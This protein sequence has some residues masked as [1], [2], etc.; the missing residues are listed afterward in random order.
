MGRP[1]PPLRPEL[2]FQD[3]GAL[4]AQTAQRNQLLDNIKRSGGRFIRTNVMYGKWQ[5][6]AYRAQLDSMVDEARKRGLGVQETLMGTPAYAAS[7]KTDALSAYHADP[8]LFGQF[9]RDVAQHFKGRVRRYSAWNEPNLSTFL[10]DHSPKRY[11]ALYD[12]SRAAIKGVVPGAQVLLG[13]LMPGDPDAKSTASVQAANFLRQV[14]AGGQAPLHAEG[15]ALHPYAWRGEAPTGASRGQGT[16][17]GINQLP[18]IQGTLADLA[19]RGR[20]TTQQGGQVPL[21]LTEFGYQRAQV[22]N[23]HARA[24]RLR[25]AYDLAAQAGAREMTFYQLRPTK[26]KPGG[27]WTWDTSVSSGGRIPQLAGTPRPVARISRAV[28]KKKR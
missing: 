19:K 9:S 8:E 25:K 11:R 6:P 1:A 28:R 21:Y 4:L 24:D 3:D 12:A 18:Q 10:A 13:E 7:A 27:G 22:P 17:A 23:D 26:R 5:D 14:V 2:A 16:Y 15:L 20:F